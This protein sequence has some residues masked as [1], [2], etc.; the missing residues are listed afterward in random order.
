MKWYR[1]D[2]LLFV[3]LMLLAPLHLSAANPRKSADSTLWARSMG[4]LHQQLA[5]ECY[6]DDPCH[7]YFVEA[8]REYGMPKASLIALDRRLRCSRIGM[9]GLNST[10]LDASGHLHENLDA[11][12]YRRVLPFDE[13]KPSAYIDYASWLADEQAG[14]RYISEDE[15]FIQHLLSL[16]L[17][18]DLS[19]MVHQPQAY[20][21]SDSVHFLRAWTEYLQQDL[22]PAAAHFSLI[23]TGSVYWEKALFHQ[24]AVLAHLSAYEQAQDR[25][26]D[27]HHGEYE[28]LKHLQSAGLALLRNDMAAYEQSS[29]AF[30]L[31][32]PHYL[33][34]DQLALQSMY[35]ERLQL[36]RKNP[37]LAASLSALVPGAGK[38]Y[39]GN[40]SEGVMS[41]VITA[42]MGA[43]TAEH[44]IKQ[45]PEDWRSITFASLTGLFYISNIFGS[46]F[47]VQILQDHVLQKQTQAILYHIH[48]PLDRIFR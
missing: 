40:L 10:F 13:R 35:E 23:D 43:L 20:H 25:L 31:Q 29:S 26:S 46:Y 16:H 22:A 33:Q 28:Q 39:A 15:D 21:L 36:G 44:M 41:F 18:Q 42:A 6:F 45:G 4:A 7:V 9:A 2:F 32:H 14:Q 48:V 1:A 27:Y 19:W 8:C 47:S 12:R 34:S 24:V 38:I 11:Y 37:W 17:T 30:D 3:W 5:G